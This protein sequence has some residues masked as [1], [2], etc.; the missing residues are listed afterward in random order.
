LTAWRAFSVHED[1][2]NRGYFRKFQWH[3]LR[4]AEFTDFWGE[5]K[6]EFG[7]NGWNFG[8]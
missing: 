1:E 5:E 6:E 4:C 7:E 2:Q 8:F 3:D